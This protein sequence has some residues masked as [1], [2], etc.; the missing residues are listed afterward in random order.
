MFLK[1]NLADISIF[2]FMITSDSHGKGLV[3]GTVLFLMLFLFGS[4]VLWA[5][6]TDTPRRGEG[7]GAFLERNGLPSKAYYDAFIRLNK[8]RLKGRE[9]LNLG[10]KYLLPEKGDTTGGSKEHSKT[11]EPGVKVGDILSEPLFGKTLEKVKVEDTSL[12]GTCFYIVSGHG[13]PDPGAIG[14]YD[15]KSLHEDEYAYDVALRLARTL[16][17][18]GATVRILVQDAKDGIRSESVL[19]TGRN[20]TLMGQAIPLDQVAR[21]KQ[22]CDKIGELSQKDSKNFSYVRAVFLHVDSRSSSQR[23]D[24]FFYYNPSHSGGKRLATNVKDVFE[25]KYRLH[26]PSRG[27]Q[28]TVGTRDLYVLAHTGVTSLFVELGNIQNAQDQRRFLLESNR[29][30]LANWMAEGLLRDFKDSKGK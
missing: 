14:K 6:K 7:I 1:T 30:A 12:S 3:S 23:I 24:V 28:G 4:Q 20:E 25:E 9:Q 10:Q 29:Q 8:D 13:G 27:F 17:Q 15:G 2:V 22:R 11:S 16:M 18:K 21:L 26:Q 19:P 5:Q